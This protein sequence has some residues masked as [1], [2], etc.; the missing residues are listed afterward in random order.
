MLRTFLDRLRRRKAPLWDRYFTVIILAAAVVAMAISMLIGLK[1]SVW[2]DEAYSIFLAEQSWSQ[3]FYLTSIDTY[4]PLYYMILKLWGEAFGW[5]EAALR[6]LSVLAL[7]GSVFVSGLLL[8]RLFGARV[9]AIAV[10]IVAVSP[11]LLRY[12]FEIRMYALGSLIGVTATYVLIL[13]HEAGDRASRLWRYGLYALLVAVGMYLFYYM[14]LLWVAHVCWLVGRTWQRERSLGGLI[15]APWLAA[16]AG[17]VI[18]FLPWMPAFFGQ[19]SNGALTTVAQSLTLDNLISVGSFLTVYE[20]LWRLG[21]I[22]SVI[23]LFALSMIGW[24]GLKAYR[25]LKGQQRAYF[26]ML[27][28]YLAVPIALLTIVGFLR[29]MYLERYLSHVAIGASMALGAAVAVVWPQVKRAGKWSIGLFAAVFV[30]GILQLSGYGN[31][32][33]QRTLH[34]AIKQAAQLAASCHDDARI[35]AGDPYAAIELLYYVKD[36]PVYFYEPSTVLTGGYAPLNMS[37]FQLKDPA[38][39][40]ADTATIY[41]IY[42]DQPRVDLST[43]R[44]LT[45]RTTFDSLSVETLSAAPRD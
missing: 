7:G 40:L 15:R 34:P 22:L 16:Y 45:K 31:Y 13:A 1:Q 23:V 20:P 32:N 10:M 43:G 5:G 39:Q 25:S 27:V 18:L 24:L 26:V 37:K 38:K 11:F 33:F 29:P 6:S 21:P 44:Q 2:F 28:L 8:R 35:V 30:V 42:Y 17:A 19:L 41:Y 12:G 14:A 3:L 4:P 36:C 9:A